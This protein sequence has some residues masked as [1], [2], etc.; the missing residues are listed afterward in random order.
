MPEATVYHSH[1]TGGANKFS[2]DHVGGGVSH[3]HNEMKKEALAAE[4]KARGGKQKSAD[5]P[6]VEVEVLPG[7]QT[8]PAGYDEHGQVIAS[9]EDRLAANTEEKSKA[10]DEEVQSKA[11]TKDVEPTKAAHTRRVAGTE[12]E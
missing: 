5:S 2:H 1:T 9:Q 12:R 11:K 4:E 3:D 10:L 7:V 6:D 8:A